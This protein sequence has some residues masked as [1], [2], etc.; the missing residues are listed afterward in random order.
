[1]DVSSKFLGTNK[2]PAFNKLSEEGTIDVLQKETS[3][4]VTFSIDAKPSKIKSSSFFSAT[5]LKKTSISDKDTGFI[6]MG[7]YTNTASDIDFIKNSYLKDNICTCI[8]YSIVIF[9]PSLWVKSSPSN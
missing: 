4:G 6:V 9:E 3:E 2:S 7:P 5:A 8:P 1:M